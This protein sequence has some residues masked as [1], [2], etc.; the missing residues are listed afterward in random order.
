MHILTISFA[1]ANLPAKLSFSKKLC[2]S[3]KQLYYVIV[4]RIP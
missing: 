2:S 1:F 4:G 3:K